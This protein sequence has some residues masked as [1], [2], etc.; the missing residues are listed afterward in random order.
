[1]TEDTTTNPKCV[2]MI[3]DGNRRWAKERNLLPWQGH[4]AGVKKLKEVTT[5]AIESKVDHLICYT[6]STEN[7]NRPKAE[8]DF[9]MKVITTALNTEMPWLLENNV[10]V[11][12][13]GDISKF[14]K[15]AQDAL[16]LLQYRTVEHTAITVTLA[17]NYG[18]RTEII[19]AINKVRTEKQNL[20][21]PVTEEEFS[22]AL[23]TA[24][25][26]DPDMI[27]RTSGEQ[28]LSGFLPW[29]GVYS[30]LFFPSVLWPDLTKEQFV[31]MLNEFASRQR[32]FGQ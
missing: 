12:V 22:A 3:L 32:R 28:R 9:L 6:F 26:P 16:A 25:I 15:S 30:E 1:M 31:G 20:L 24:L 5:W 11:K 23:D 7:W 10:K 8:V 2:G 14:T 17:L 4:E 21:E 19:R 29:Q 18:G 13:I 27:I